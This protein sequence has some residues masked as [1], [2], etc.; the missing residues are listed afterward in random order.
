M[1]ECPTARRE[2]LTVEAIDHETLVYDAADKRAHCLNRAAALVWGYCDGETTVTEMAAR[3]AAEMG[4]PVDEDIVRLA[5]RDLGERGLLAQAAPVPSAAALDRRQLLV[6]LGA[7]AAVMVPVITSL[8]A[9]SSAAAQSGS[10]S[11]G[12]SSGSSGSSGGS[13]GS[14]GSS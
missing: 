12:S 13:S 4:G 8:V 2:G 9:P 3:L 7:A 14:S 1:T 10:S 5:L 11:S 6:R